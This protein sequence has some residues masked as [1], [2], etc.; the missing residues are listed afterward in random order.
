MLVNPALFADD[1]LNQQEFEA[2]VESRTTQKIVK[3]I[4]EKVQAGRLELAQHCGVD[5]V[6]DRFQSGLLTG[7]ELGHDYKYLFE[8]IGEQEDGYG[9]KTVE[10]SRT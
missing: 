1:T 7:M 4:K 9:T 6:A 5:P 10:S 2:W 3:L 8:W